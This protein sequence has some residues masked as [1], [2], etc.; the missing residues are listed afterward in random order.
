MMIYKPFDSV[1]KI[2]GKFVSASNIKA[3]GSRAMFCVR[4]I[5]HARANNTVYLTFRRL[6][7][8]SHF[9]GAYWWRLHQ[10]SSKEQC[11]WTYLFSKNDLLV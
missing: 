11:L 4:Y 5:S 1:K 8:G 2:Q 6:K 7:F 3:K 10:K 9:F